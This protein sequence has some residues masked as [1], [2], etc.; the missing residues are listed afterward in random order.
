[1]E[2]ASKGLLIAGSVLIVILLISFG[3]SLLGNIQPTT[4]SVKETMTATEI[5][6]FNSKFTAY[7]G[8]SKPASQAKALAQLVIS[9]N[10]VNSRKVKI[11]IGATTYDTTTHASEVTTAVAGLSGRGKI[12][13][14]IV[15]GVVDE[16]KLTY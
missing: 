5:A 7:V 1:M 14:N 6:Q 8:T 12:E 10:T 16:V 2:N 3:V 13:V 9:S 4:D 11:T 15:N